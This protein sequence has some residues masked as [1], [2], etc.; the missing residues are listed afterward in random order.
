[1]VASDESLPA[2]MFA[3]I[4]LLLKHWTRAAMRIA[5]KYLSRSRKDTGIR[6]M[7]ADVI[8]YYEL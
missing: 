6:K 2:N 3:E 1:M 4:S 8:A 5:K 7:T